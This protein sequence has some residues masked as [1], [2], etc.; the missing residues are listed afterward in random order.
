MSLAKRISL[1]ETVIRQ[2]RQITQLQNAVKAQLVIVRELQ[3]EA[4]RNHSPLSAASSRGATRR[5]T[6][7]A[8]ALL[9]KA[10][11]NYVANEVNR[12]RNAV[13]RLENL[14]G[15]STSSF[16][17]NSDELSL[18]ERILRKLDRAEFQAYREKEERLRSGSRFTGEDFDRI[19]RLVR[20][21]VQVLVHKDLDARIQAA[22]SGTGDI[23]KL[24]FAVNS[25]AYR[26]M[27]AERELFESTSTLKAMKSELL[28]RKI[29]RDKTNSCNDDN[30]GEP[31][32]VNKTNNDQAFKRNK[33]LKRRK[34]R[35]LTQGEREADISDTNSDSE[36][37]SIEEKGNDSSIDENNDGDDDDGND[38][39]CKG[40]NSKV[41]KSNFSNTS[42][43]GKKSNSFPVTKLKPSLKSSAPVSVLSMVTENKTD[44]AAILGI[45]GSDAAIHFTASDRDPMQR[46]KLGRQKFTSVARR[47]AM[48]QRG[49]G[50]RL[51]SLVM[52]TR[53]G[54]GNNT[55]ASPELFSTVQSNTEAVRAATTAIANTNTLAAKRSADVDKRLGS[56]MLDMSTL[57]EQLLECDEKVENMTASID[58]SSRVAA[59]ALEQSEMLKGTKMRFTDILKAMQLRLLSQSSEVS[60]MRSDLNDSVEN[61]VEKMKQ[62]HRRCDEI[63][64]K[65]K[66]QNKVESEFRHLIRMS[67]ESA[68]SSEE[69]VKS[70]ER[71]ID[72]ELRNAR[73]EVRGL[74][75]E[76][77]RKE[78]KVRN[79]LLQ[80]KRW[81][82]EK[83]DEFDAFEESKKKY[84]GNWER[85]VS[86]VAEPITSIS[87]S[88]ELKF[89]KKK[90]IK[91]I[92]EEEYL[93]DVLSE[94]IQSIKRNTTKLRL[95][96][97]K[98]IR[99]GENGRSKT[100]NPRRG[101]RKVK[102]GRRK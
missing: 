72:D 34:E 98:E 63:Y 50:A 82:S 23:N 53:G 69:L 55:T 5:E 11:K 52:Q 22:V 18:Q 54:N 12:L 70:C 35:I 102:F 41:K 92:K 16:N 46:R 43:V 29:L 56:L 68:K 86:E 95:K 71:K 79:S 74:E 99:K 32:N 76:N 6:G 73:E 61:S 48:K 20:D 39:E 101:K 10:D 33:I 84:R 24:N 30:I 47:V 66:E 62:L 31:L 49:N 64:E 87:D 3:R 44:E 75:Y 80:E 51:R 38:T 42:S 81:M 57:R 26:V 40:E 65:Q 1:E 90:K 60:L 59:E 27:E 37:E 45:G 25:L 78:N 67:V 91:S 28:K 17:N 85:G 4:A 58:E 94:R 89:S 9:L 97:K 8:A 88:K 83:F 7:V 93:N 19:K 77:R 13:E 15:I 14:N 21:T 2:Q 96:A 100:T 36:S